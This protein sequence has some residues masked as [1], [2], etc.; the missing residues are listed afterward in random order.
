MLIQEIIFNYSSLSYNKG[1]QTKF[2]QTAKSAKSDFLVVGTFLCSILFFSIPGD[3]PQK[4]VL[5]LFVF[6]ESQ[7]TSVK[8]TEQSANLV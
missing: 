6:D 2:K 1:S 3:L 7:K 8:G 4:T 5:D